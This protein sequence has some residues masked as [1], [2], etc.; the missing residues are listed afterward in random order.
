MLPRNSSRSPEHQEASVGK[1]QE[2]FGTTT[3]NSLQYFLIFHHNYIIVMP[4]F[5]YLGGGV[6]GA[7]GYFLSYM[8]MSYV[9][10]E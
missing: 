7:L 3:Y 1:E 8:C 4:L 5:F 9:G 2:H 6:G 10:G